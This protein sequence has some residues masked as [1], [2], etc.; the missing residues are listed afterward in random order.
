[1][2]AG[3]ALVVHCRDR[4]LGTRPHT[5]CLSFIITSC[6]SGATLVT[7]DKSENQSLLCL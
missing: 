7:E 3:V 5:W 6:V 4:L 1:M 2:K